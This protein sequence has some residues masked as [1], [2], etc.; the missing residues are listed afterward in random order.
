MSLPPRPFTGAVID[1][2]TIEV[3]TDII[4]IIDPIT[5]LIIGPITDTTNRTTPIAMGPVINRTPLITA[6]ITALIIRFTAPTRGG[7]DSQAKQGFIL[8]PIIG[9]RERQE[10]HP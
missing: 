8:R 2:G 6:A 10:F 4:L 3:T 9:S 1:A 5:D 7:I